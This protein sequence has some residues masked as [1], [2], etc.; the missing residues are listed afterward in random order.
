MIHPNLETLNQEACHSTPTS[1]V[2]DKGKANPKSPRGAPQRRPPSTSPGKARRSSGS[3]KNPFEKIKEL[4]KSRIDDLPDTALVEMSVQM[5]KKKRTQN[6]PDNWTDHRTNSKPRDSIR[7]RRRLYDTFI[8]KVQDLKEITDVCNLIFGEIFK[9]TAVGIEKGTKSMEKCVQFGDSAV[10]PRSMSR[11]LFFKAATIA[12]ADGDEEAASLYSS[13]HY[14]MGLPTTNFGFNVDLD[15]DRG[16][17][18]HLHDKVKITTSNPPETY[19]AVTAEIRAIIQDS[20]PEQGVSISGARLLFSV[21]QR[22]VKVYIEAQKTTFGSETNATTSLEPVPPASD[23]WGKMPIWSQMT[24]ESV[25][26]M[27]PPAQEIFKRAREGEDELLIRGENS[28]FV[29]WLRYLIFL[30][31]EKLDIGPSKR[32]GILSHMLQTKHFD[33]LWSALTEANRQYILANVFGLHG[34]NPNERARN[35]AS[36]TSLRRSN[37]KSILRDTATWNHEV[38]TLTQKFGRHSVSRPAQAGMHARKDGAGAGGTEQPS[39]KP[40]QSH[41]SLETP[42]PC[43]WRLVGLSPTSIP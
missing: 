10:N 17:C 22:A 14:V 33:S 29:Q 28:V 18:H 8:K 24:Q 32:W 34:S 37:D 27:P 20:S 39:S 38:F 41:C 19:T 12:D 11:S 26:A 43:R 6:R 25:W 21:L 4:M 13:M 15:M 36:K 9:F 3:P 40:H 30:M 2:A 16:N 5:E 31:N 1:T 7:M 35:S 42:Q 23:T